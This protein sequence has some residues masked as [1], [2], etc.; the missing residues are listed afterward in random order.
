MFVKFWSVPGFERA[1]VTNIFLS[2]FF[3]SCGVAFVLGFKERVLVADVSFEV[4]L[5]LGSVVT[6]LTQ[7]LLVAVDQLDVNLQI[8]W[9]QE[10]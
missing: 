7:E 10:S 9:E 1:F 4:D 2:F 3:E 6:E 5:V 8:G